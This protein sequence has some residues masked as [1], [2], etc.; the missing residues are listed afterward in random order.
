MVW[1]GE[2]TFL[3]WFG[4]RGLKCIMKIIMEEINSLRVKMGLQERT[5]KQVLDR[6]EAL[7][8]QYKEDDNG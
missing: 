8:E 3:N 1:K 4:L 2:R 5:W 6:M 7:M